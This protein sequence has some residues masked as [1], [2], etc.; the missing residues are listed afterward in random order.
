MANTGINMLIENS[1]TNGDTVSLSPLGGYYAFRLMNVVGDDVRSIDLTDKPGV[2]LLSDDAAVVIDETPHTDINKRDGQCM[3]AITPQEAADLLEIQ[4]FSIVY[5]V[6]GIY[7]TLFR[8]VFVDINKKDD[9]DSS[10]LED[11]LQRAASA[12]SL[13]ADYLSKLNALQADYDSLSSSSGSTISELQARVAEL[14]GELAT[15]RNSMISAN[16]I[17][18]L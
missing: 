8:G 3:F 2:Q 12:E 10:S 6:A 11:A 18:E 13:A 7:V 4:N 1:L 5:N 9:E 16:I 14:E 15:L 17:D